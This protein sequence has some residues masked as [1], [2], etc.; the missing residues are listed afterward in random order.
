MGKSLNS[1]IDAVVED[2]LGAL[3]SEADEFRVCPI[4]LIDLSTTELGRET[5]GR[6]AEIVIMFHYLWRRPTSLIGDR[7]FFD[8]RFWYRVHP[9]IGAFLGVDRTAASN[10]RCLCD[11]DSKNFSNHLNS[12]PDIVDLARREFYEIK[13]DTDGD[14]ADGQSYSYRATGDVAERSGRIDVRGVAGDSSALGA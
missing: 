9:N 10:I 7:I 8:N 3:E 5:A 1:A 12:R 14:R 6:T 13:P 4:N 11:N 2:A